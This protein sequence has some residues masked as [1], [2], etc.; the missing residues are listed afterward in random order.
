MSNPSM[1]GI[2][3]VGM[4]DRTPE[5]RAVELFS[6]GV[7]TPFK[8]EFSKKVLN[9]LQKET[10]IHKLLLKERIN[11]RREFFRVSLE[12]VKELFNLMDGD[13]WVCEVKEET[14]DKIRNENANGSS[15]EVGDLITGRWFD[16]KRSIATGIITKIHSDKFYINLTEE[17]STK[18]KIG[19]EMKLFQKNCWDSRE[20]SPENWEEVGRWRPK[21]TK[22]QIKKEASA[23]KKREVELFKEQI[24]ME[25]W[26]IKS[27]TVASGKQKG[28]VQKSY[29][30]PSPYKG[31]FLGL[32]KAMDWY[33]IH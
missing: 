8:I 33:N 21:Q 15:Q 18:Y 19:T 11:P 24:K 12:K 20:T 27:K 26:V 14:M 9:P 29:K 25:D 30:P 10:T 5:V 16:G 4:T 1:P 23:K 6:T 32:Q 13:V 17:Y 28:Q 2:L 22:K 31:K 7:P 3:K